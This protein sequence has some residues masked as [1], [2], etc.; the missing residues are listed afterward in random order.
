M[1]GQPSPRSFGLDDLADAP[2]WWE[3]IV[4]GLCAAVYLWIMQAQTPNGDGRVY[5][6]IVESGSIVWNPNHLLMAP[7]GL[8][9]Y[10]LLQAIGLDWSI[11]ASLKALSGLATVATVVLVYR[12]IPLRSSGLRAL[13][14][15]AIFFSADFLSMAIA[16]E[17]FVVQMPVLAALLGLGMRVV[18]G[19]KPSMEP[20]RLATMGVLAAVAAAI[21][22]NNALL[23]IALGPLVAYR[24]G[25]RDWHTV[26]R[27]LVQLWGPGIVV[28][29]PIL[30]GCYFVS[31]TDH[32]LLSW[33]TAYQGDPDGGGGALY[34][35]RWDP[36]GLIIGAARLVYGFVNSLVVLGQLGAAAKSL[37]FG[38]PIEFHLDIVGAASMALL[39]ATIGSLAAGFFWW[40]IRHGYRMPL[41]RFGL[42][43]IGAYLLFNFIFSDISDQFWFQVLL[44]LWVLLAIF[45][46]NRTAA[47]SE[48]SRGLPWSHGAFV[49][50][51]LL[52]SVGNTLSV[53]APRAFND[54]A[55]FSASFQTLLTDGDLL[56][57]TGWDDLSWVVPRERSQV[58]RVLLM[59]LAMQQYKDHHSL[60]DLPATVDAQLRQG[61]RVLLARVYDKDHEGRPWEQLTK[62]GWPR[63]RI[64]ALFSSFDN[65]VVGTVGGVVIRQ[66]EPRPAS[67]ASASGS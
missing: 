29:V 55:A 36:Q 5:I 53:A 6:R 60:D 14:V 45:V 22:V 8:A 65:R 13:T 49:V 21:S 37:L 31:G 50:S 26:G 34:G 33:L 35:I 2:R 40:A 67:S 39:F 1:P 19:D 17:Y 3:G 43:W 32:G 20:R 15:A 23:A 59:E 56:I 4:A 28:G 16:E 11:F 10:C 58:K 52:L 44:P 27:R 61:G 51:V 9:W 12:A 48:G 18:Q 42:G 46:S 41:V 24:P 7:I 38:Q 57:T 25:D 30:L 64:Q 66:L 47:S 54:T 62:L 63:H